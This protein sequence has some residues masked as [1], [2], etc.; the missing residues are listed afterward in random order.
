MEQYYEGFNDAMQELN[1]MLNESIKANGG[2]RT[3]A[4]A[5]RVAS[6]VILFTHQQ[7]TR[8]RNEQNDIQGGQQ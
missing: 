2:L 1:V 8:I 4:Q 7:A 5:W 6:D 3:H